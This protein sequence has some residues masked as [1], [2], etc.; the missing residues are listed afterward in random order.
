M[1]I[2]VM[3]GDQDDGHWEGVSRDD[4]RLPRLINIQDDPFS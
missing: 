4:T 1:T 3:F 2:A